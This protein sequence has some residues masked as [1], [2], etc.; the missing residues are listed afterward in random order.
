MS[1]R[2]DWALWRSRAGVADLDNADSATNQ[3]LG[4]SDGKM[5]GKPASLG[6][7]SG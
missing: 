5:V 6:V 4:M 7:V 1:S 2:S 3:A